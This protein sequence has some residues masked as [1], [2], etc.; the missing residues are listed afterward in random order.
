MTCSTS[1]RKGRDVKGEPLT[2]TALPA[3]LAP[4]EENPLGDYQAI[5]V[6]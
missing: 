4:V 6:P 2:R 5:R 3:A 1:R